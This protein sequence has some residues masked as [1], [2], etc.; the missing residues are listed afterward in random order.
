MENFDLGTALMEMETE[1]KRCVL[2][3]VSVEEI[4]KLQLPPRENILSPW[5][6]SQGIVMVYGPRG[7]G[8][9]LFSMGCAVA[10]ASG[11]GFLKWHSEKPYGVLYVDGEMPAIVI[12][13]RLSN[14][15]VGNEKEPIAPL[16][17]ITPDLQKFGVPDLSTLE[18]QVAV[19]QHLNDI[20]LVIVD[21]I[22][23]LCRHG[24]ENE[25]ESW[26]PIQEWAL[27]L[28]SQHISVLFVHHSGK[29]GLQRGT[30]RREDVLDTVISLKRPADYM[31]D[32]GARFEVHFEKNRGFYGDEAKP[33]EAKLFQKDNQQCWTHK[34][35]EDSKVERVAKLLNEGIPQKELAEML[36]VRKGTISK[37]KQSAE[38]RGL[39][40]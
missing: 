37:Y 29:G 14:I 9:T 7:I 22:S 16:K 26:L 18:G 1:Q 15:I 20:S 6:P 35:L 30:S 8:K 12:Q 32:E 17:I 3:A 4:L 21:N 27:R 39:L 25:G 36:G 19:E 38:K 28:R 23:T 13:E 2:K 33:F 5:L 10:I 24:R 40:K 34:D 31:P 11:N